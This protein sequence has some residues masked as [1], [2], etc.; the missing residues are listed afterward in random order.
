MELPAD[1]QLEFGD[2]KLH[3]YKFVDLDAIIGKTIVGVGTA[4]VDGQY[5]LE[6]ATIL[7]FDDGTFHGFVHPKDE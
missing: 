7:L 5:G 6:P 2:K 4:N 3:D 1:F